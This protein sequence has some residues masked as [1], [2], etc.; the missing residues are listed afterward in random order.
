MH[1]TNPAY[2]SDRWYARDQA[3]PHFR[4]GAAREQGSERYMPDAANVPRADALD[5]ERAQHSEPGADQYRTDVL[6]ALQ[7]A[8]FF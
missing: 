6:A 5:E 3:P 8:G 4:A 7:A 1:G 2:H